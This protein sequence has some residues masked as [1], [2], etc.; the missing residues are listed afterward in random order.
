[1]FGKAQEATQSTNSWPSRRNSSGVMWSP[2]TGG[3]YP[4]P[5]AGLPAG[6]GATALVRVV[7]H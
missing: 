5:P 3:T 7:F 6:A 1:M 2:G 4:E